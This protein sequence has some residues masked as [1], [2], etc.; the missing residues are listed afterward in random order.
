M[1]SDSWTLV[2]VSYLQN[3]GEMVCQFAKPREQRSVRFRFFPT[4]LSSALPEEFKNALPLPVFRQL[5]LVKSSPNASVWLANRFS[6]LQKLSGFIQ[7]KLNKDCLLLEPERQFLLQ[8]NWGY[9]DSFSLET[10]SPARLDSFS[11]PFSNLGF[12]PSDFESVLADSLQRDETQTAKTLIERV[13]WSNLLK[14]PAVDVPDAA[15][16]RERKWMQNHFF[17]SGQ[18][19]NPANPTPKTK[20]NP[21]PL[22]VFERTTE[23][24]FGNAV[25]LLCTQ[26]YYNLG[27]ETL[28]CSC[29]KPENAASQNLL[30]HSLVRVR[31]LQ[32]A[33]FFD[34]VF[35]DFA[36]RFH[37]NQPFKAERNEWQF[38]YGLS[39]P[40][41][42]PFLAG[43]IAEVPLADALQLE[44]NLQV[45]VI[46]L[47]SNLAWSCENRESFLSAELNGFSRRVLVSQQEL[48]ALEKNALRTEPLK[49]W[50]ELPRNSCWF[51]WSLNSDFWQNRF[52]ELPGILA[53]H[54]TK[55]N[56]ALFSGRAWTLA[57]FNA[58]NASQGQ[59]VLVS[60]FLAKAFVPNA[61]GASLAFEFAKDRK[62]PAPQVLDWHFWTP[63]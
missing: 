50:S 45:V 21:L 46:G 1:T 49:N 35:S 37:Q 48:S 19:P 40:P 22:R 52:L 13:L 27:F 58:F 36:N 8:Q 51:F 20:T 4:L 12:L 34:T 26:A 28:N 62:W 14:I 56:Q 29:C 39:W 42:G 54:S 31:I 10:V 17:L 5:H 7:K 38:E 41:I 53:L 43:Q 23:F 47:G 57:Q 63:V 25:S 60:P 55:L 24:D 11:L 30:P 59:R 6:L 33:F 32:N 44:Q 15:I 9:F 61:S 3:R 2:S 18:I 16:E